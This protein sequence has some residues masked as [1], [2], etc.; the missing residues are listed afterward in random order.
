MNNP[1]QNHVRYEVITQEDD[2]GDILLPIPPMLLK[3]LKWKEGDEI[4]FGVDENGNY[5][6]KKKV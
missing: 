3:K 1:G 4:E 6:L 5:I 2:S